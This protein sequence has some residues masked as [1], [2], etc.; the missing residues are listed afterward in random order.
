[1]APAIVCL[2]GLL[3]VGRLPICPDRAWRLEAGVCHYATPTPC[4]SWR[5]Q[6]D[7][8]AACL[9]CGNMMYR[10]LWSPF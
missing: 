3:K 5:K 10:V 6:S 2:S 9:S 7:S 4:N 1:M 8:P